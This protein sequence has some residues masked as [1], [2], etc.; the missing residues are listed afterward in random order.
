MASCIKETRPPEEQQIAVIDK[1]DDA[2]PA[3]PPQTGAPPSNE[4]LG[5]TAANERSAQPTVSPPPL[6]VP[7]LIAFE[8]RLRTARPR[9]TATLAITVVNIIVFAIMALQYGRVVD[10]TSDSL[11]SWGAAYAPR[12]F[13][14]QWWR[15]VTSQFLHGGLGHLSANLCFL[16]LISPLLER[17][18]GPARFLV[19]Y[20]FA[21]LGGALL[22]LGWFPASVAVGASAAV[23][24][25]YGA[26]LGCYLRSPR[27]IPWQ[28][29]GRHIGVLV[30][31]TFMSLLF[32]YLDLERNLIAHVGGFVFGFAG[33]L[34]FGHALRA[35]GTSGKLRRLV[36]ALAVCGGVLS[37]TGWS[38]QRCAGKT[39][40]LLARYEAMLDR[41]RALLGCFSD[42]LKRRGD[43][44]AKD[45][46]LRRLLQGQLI[47]EWECA[48]AQLNLQLP[49]EYAALE[50]RRLSI[51]DLFAQARSSGQRREPG[52]SCA[53]SSEE[54]DAMYRL[55]LKLR[56]DNWRVLAD[57]L[58]SEDSCGGEI[59]IDLVWIEIL[60][61]ELN[62]MANE[63]N[64]L[65]QWLDF[66]RRMGGDKKQSR[67]AGG[68]LSWRTC[69]IVDPVSLDRRIHIIYWPVKGGR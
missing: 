25:L 56:V 27:T 38:M 65:R 35:N 4:S 2:P 37:L 60:R 66:S 58:A 7:V 15:A 32:N 63:G 19:V 5:S 57:G 33:G 3:L 48:R 30:A 20:L 1:R 29:F 23:Y 14:G 67:S 9:I 54:F 44:D 16:L 12:T 10:F 69:K 41:E 13:H 17:L 51:R 45:E 42:G 8:E 11:L 24:G 62:E 26:L 36:I 28:I 68:K 34:L 64:P 22:G 31:Y 21:G 55:Y 47:P 59:L 53:R 6:H 49:Y 50:R 39:I 43:G 61:D 18:L 46:D 40:T 52:G